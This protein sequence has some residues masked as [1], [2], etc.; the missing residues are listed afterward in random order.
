[1]G[2]RALIYQDPFPRLAAWAGIG[3]PVRALTAEPRERKSVAGGCQ[4]RSGCPIRSGMTKRGDPSPTSWSAGL[5]PA[6]AWMPDQ[7][8]H[9]E[10]GGDRRDPG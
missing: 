8:G 5:W 9:D 2:S 6:L 7:I 4:E 1:M 3:R 10:A